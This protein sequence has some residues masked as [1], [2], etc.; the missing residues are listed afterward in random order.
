MSSSLLKLP[1]KRTLFSNF[2]ANFGF[3]VICII[4]ILIF[5]LFIINTLLLLKSHFYKTDNVTNHV[6]DVNFK[7]SYILNKPLDI[8]YKN[9]MYVI[10]FIVVCTFVYTL[11]QDY[12]YF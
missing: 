11:L 12:N 8:L 9:I 1:E 6:N 7:W 3:L 2:C 10:I 4:I 5:V